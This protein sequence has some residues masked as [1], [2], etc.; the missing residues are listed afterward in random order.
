MLFIVQYE[1]MSSQRPHF[2]SSPPIK[3]HENFAIDLSGNWMKPNMLDES[4]TNYIFAK[5]K[6]QLVKYVKYCV[7]IVLT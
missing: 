6:A 3:V 7:E 1:N 4:F 5:L 2:P